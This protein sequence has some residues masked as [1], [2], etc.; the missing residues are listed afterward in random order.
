MSTAIDFLLLSFCIAL[1]ILQHVKLVNYTLFVHVC[2]MKLCMSV[3]DQCGLTKK[4]KTRRQT[5]EQDCSSGG[6][7]DGANSNNSRKV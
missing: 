6:G 4:I 3:K 5:L 2:A 7:G 1:S